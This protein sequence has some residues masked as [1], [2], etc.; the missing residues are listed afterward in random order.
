MGQIT[1]NTVNDALWGNCVQISNGIVELLVTVDYGPRVIHFARVG[2]ENMFY[3]DKTKSYLDKP[4]DCYDDQQILY[5][6]HRLWIAP[7]IVPRCYHPD[8]KSVEWKQTEGGILF[9][10]AVEEGSKVQKAMLISIQEDEPLVHIEHSVKNCGLWDIE[11]APWC[12]TMLEKG[13]KEIIPVPQTKSGLLPNRSVTLWD[14]SEMNDSRV[15]LGKKYITM[16]QDTNKP[17]PFKLGINNED[18]WAA[19]FNKGQVFVKYFVPS[20]DG[21]YPDNGCSFES[22][23]NDVMLEC[24]SLGEFVSL[25]PGEICYYSEE[26]ELHE[27]AAAPSNNE[28]EIENVMK[29]I[30]E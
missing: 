12:I 8:N 15:Y 30:I 6:G 9:T 11:L 25:E 24:E 7:E 28:D 27:A 18:G 29:G 20:P 23:T 22:Y 5:G 1:V 3:Q 17:N 16:T 13:G 2:M 21:Y 10:A 14:Y 26:W 19:Y 4:F